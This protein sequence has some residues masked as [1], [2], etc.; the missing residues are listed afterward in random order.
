[1]LVSESAERN[2]THISEVTRYFQASLTH[3]RSS[4]SISTK[5]TSLKL[6]LALANIPLILPNKILNVHSGLPN[7]GMTKLQGKIPSFLFHTPSIAAYIAK[8]GVKNVVGPVKLDII[9][10]SDSPSFKQDFFDGMVNI[11]MIHISPWQ[12]TLSLMECK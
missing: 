10:Y 3:S 6:P 5:E 4:P 7:L 2:R 1:M 8:T 9:A 11:N 12:T